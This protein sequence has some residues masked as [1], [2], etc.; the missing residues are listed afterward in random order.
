[1][2][3]K[4]DEMWA[5]LEAHKPDASYADA[6]ATMLK[7]R[8]VASVWAAY[9]AAPKR[10]AVQNAVVTV[11]AAVAWAADAA[12]GSAA[13]SAAAIAADAADYYAQEAI[14]AIKEVKP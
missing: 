6:W 9:D 10:A 4:L 3:A 2:S 11:A 14:D 7:E 13:R 5:A 1:V 8:T 12:S